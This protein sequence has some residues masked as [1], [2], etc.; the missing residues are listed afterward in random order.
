MTEWRQYGPIGV[1]FDVIAFICTP[2]ICQLLEQLQRNEAAALGIDPT[3]RQLVN[4]VKTRGNSY[5]D[6]FVR[7]NELYDSLDN[8]I[9]QKLRKYSTSTTTRQR[10]TCDPAVAAIPPVV[11]TKRRP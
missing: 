3:I 1:L 4:S 6:T 9:E 2:Q 7:A 8:Y 5:Y 10:R 11:Y